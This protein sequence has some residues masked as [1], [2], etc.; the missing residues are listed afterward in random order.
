M[1]LCIT[2]AIINYPINYIAILRPFPCPPPPKKKKKKKN[3]NSIVFGSAYPNYVRT[4]FKTLLQKQMLSQVTF[5]G[6]PT[7]LITVS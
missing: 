2:G 6:F 1:Q 4:H 7:S 3:R 5:N